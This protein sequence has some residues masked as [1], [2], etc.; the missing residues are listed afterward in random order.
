MARKDTTDHFTPLVHASLCTHLT[1]V[2]VQDPEHNGE[3]ELGSV[4]SEKPLR[5]KHVGLNT[6]GL[7]V[8]VQVR[9]NFLVGQNTGG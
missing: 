8:L 2:D 3:G 9:E 1:Q 6:I 5:G 4:E 7:H